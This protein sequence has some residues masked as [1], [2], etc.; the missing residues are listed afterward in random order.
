MANAR[1]VFLSQKVTKPLQSF[2]FLDLSLSPKHTSHT[3]RIKSDQLA[4]QISTCFLLHYGIIQPQA[5]APH[6]SPHIA[7]CCPKAQKIPK[8][9][10]RFCYAYK[11][12]DPGT[13]YWKLKKKKVCFLAQTSGQNI[14]M[15]CTKLPQSTAL[16]PLASSQKVWMLSIFSAPRT[17]FWP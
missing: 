17:A 6:T 15:K 14:K 11:Y 8:K 5:Q 13:I 12:Q 7:T 2:P 16:F 4:L 3:H 1:L 10:K 9:W